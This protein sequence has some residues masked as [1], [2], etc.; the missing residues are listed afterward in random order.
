[1]NLFQ[2]MRDFA[3]VQRDAMTTLIDALA[4]FV[5]P[6]LPAEKPARLALRAAPKPKR[7]VR[8]PRKSRIAKAVQPQA[9][10]FA[11]SAARD[12]AI[13]GALRRSHGVGTSKD[14]KAA[15]PK[16]AGQSDE[17]RR[18]A[19]SNTMTRLKNTNRVGRTGDTWSLVGAGS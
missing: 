18:A 15:L 2:Q 16:E 1:M 10:T 19:F 4:P 14:L 13:L 8:R 5:G 3:L 7:T 9:K 11:Q 12:E 6:A 17:Q